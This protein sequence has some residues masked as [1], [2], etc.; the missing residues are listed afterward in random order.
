MYRTNSYPSKADKKCYI[1]VQPS[2]SLLASKTTTPPTAL[3]NYPVENQVYDLR[4]KVG[5]YTGRR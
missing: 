1:S 2:G 5:Q 4:L 3:N